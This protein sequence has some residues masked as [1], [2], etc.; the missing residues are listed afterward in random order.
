MNEYSK[1]MNPDGS[2]DGVKVH[3][4]LAG[5]VFA[6]Q[7]EIK[8]GWSLEAHGHDHDH[9]SLLPV[10][11][12]LLTVDGLEQIYTGPTGINIKAGKQHSI[13][14]LSD[15]IWIC[16]W[17]AKAGQSLQEIEDDILGVANA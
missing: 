4:Y 2:A 12:V 11:Q 13:L 8:A 15:S 17:P 1:L 14:A 6:K 9:L 10:G 16:T 7:A 5:G 3:H